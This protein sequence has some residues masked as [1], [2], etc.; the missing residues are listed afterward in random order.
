MKGFAA[1]HC[2]RIRCAA[3]PTQIT[4][5]IAA[6]DARQAG[7]ENVRKTRN[8]DYVRIGR[9]TRYNITLANKIEADTALIFNFLAR[10]FRY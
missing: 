5:K 1:D 8:R 7:C 4:G 10:P 9:R 2:I 3:V 6:W